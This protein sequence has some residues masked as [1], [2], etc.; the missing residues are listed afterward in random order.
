MESG[1]TISSMAAVNFFLKMVPTIKVLS[2]MGLQKEKVAT[3]LIMVV[4][5]RA[6]FIIT[7]QVEKEFILTLFSI[8]ST[9]GNGFKMCRMEWGNKNFRMGLIMKVSLLRE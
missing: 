5:I 7:K 6:R 2:D 4:F 9:V 8:I 3:Y 1:R